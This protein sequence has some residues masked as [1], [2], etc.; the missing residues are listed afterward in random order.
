M[1]VASLAKIEVDLLEILKVGKMV[2]L[3][4]DEMEQQLGS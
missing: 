4:V 1:K 3:L 2:C